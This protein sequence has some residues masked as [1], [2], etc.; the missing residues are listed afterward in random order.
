MVKIWR[1]QRSM[2]TPFSVGFLVDAISTLYRRCI[3]STAVEKFVAVTK[4]YQNIANLFL[5]TVSAIRL[6]ILV[7]VKRLFCPVCTNSGNK[8]NNTQQHEG[9]LYWS[10][11]RVQLMLIGQAHY[12]ITVI[13][14]RKSLVIYCLSCLA[15]GHQFYRGYAYHQSV[16]NRNT[17]SR[18]A[19]AWPCISILTWSRTLVC[20]S[21]LANL[22]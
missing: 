16:N 21:S 6:L 4:D 19:L 14:I 22:A 3:D 11:K 5:P 18:L 8:T 20:A 13:A 10:S 17:V 2:T 7:A 1:Y 9:P 15:Y 12:L